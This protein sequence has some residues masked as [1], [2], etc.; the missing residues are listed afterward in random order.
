M[1]I[2]FIIN[3]LY[4]PN[5]GLFPEYAGGLYDLGETDMVVSR[6]LCLDEKPRVFNPP[7]IVFINIEPK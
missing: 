5:Q 3:G 7:E 2:P 4:A 1:R 6:G